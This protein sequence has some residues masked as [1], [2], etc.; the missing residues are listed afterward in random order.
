MDK[1]SKIYKTVKKEAD[2]KFQSKTGIYKSAWIVKE[3]KKRGGIFKEKKPTK[4]Q[5][6]LKRWFEEEWVR[7]DKN[8][9]IMKDKNENV[10]CGRNK[11]EMDDNVTKGLCRPSKRITK[12]TPKT[13]KELGPK[14]L[15]D[16]YKRKKK[17]PN[18]TII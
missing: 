12:D 13:V 2:T 3:Y 8:G 4:K 18:K 6:G 14:V 7:V 15:K 11:E 16:R 10:P 9:D 1:E 5:S 17:N